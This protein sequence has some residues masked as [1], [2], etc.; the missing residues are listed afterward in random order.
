MSLSP[1]NPLTI[2]AEI[3]KQGEKAVSAYAE[4]LDF[5]QVLVSQ[6]TKQLSAVAAG[7]DG[8]A[9][10]GGDG[11]SDASSGASGGPFGAGQQAGEYGGLIDGALTSAIMGGGGLGIAAEVA[12]GL[13]PAIKIPEG[14]R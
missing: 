1:I 4:G 5:E 10:G 11:S 8:S 6:L 7:P 14:R 12:R 13:D 3:R 2:P 9:S